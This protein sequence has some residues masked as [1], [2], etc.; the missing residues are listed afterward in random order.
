MENIADNKRIAKNTVLLYIRTIVIMVVSLYTSRVVLAALGV[1]DYGIFNAV[2]GVV[3]MFSVI[4]G[5]L[6][7]SISRYITFELGH[8][9]YERLKDIFSTSINIQL[10]ISII[11][12]VLGETIGLWF[13][14][15]KMNIPVERLNAANWVLHCSLLSFVFNLLS[16]PYNAVIIAHEK[17]SAF[18]YVSIAEVTLKLLIVYALFISPWD[19]LIVYAVLMV[20]VSVVIRLVY[21]FYCGKHFDETKYKRVKNKALV[22]EMTGFAGWGFLTN[23]AYIFNTQGVNILINLFFGVAV[24]AARGI[25]TQ[26]E[27]AL[28]QFVNNFTMA[29][30][31]QITKL[32]AS[33]HIGEMNKLVIRGAK[34]S[35]YLSL[36]ICLPLI[37]EAPYVL[38]LWLVEVPDHTVAFV[39]LS[40]IATMAD[41]I[42][43]TS[44]T[45]CMATGTIK[46]YVLWITS[47]G[48]LVFPLTY[49]AYKFGA[50]VETT[51]IIFFVVYIILDIVRLII[52]KG[53][54]PFPIREFVVEVFLKTILVTA[55]SIVIPLICLYSLPSSFFRLI[56]VILISI[57][58]TSF[59]TYLF[60]LKKEERVSLRMWTKTVYLER[61]KPFIAR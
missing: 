3:A 30:N 36:M 46:K 50:T 57:I 39:R 53:L 31:P 22:R 37:L 48:F 16:I 7:T 55:L 17:M 24:N 19:K 2:G 51:Y 21:G 27:T 25:A 20:L 58:S 13:L 15:Y 18:A 47:I 52:M 8:G 1:D 35:F 54:F 43:G 11:I 44:Y 26:V 28:S 4:S 9:D 40:I 41:R 49:I 10:V 6:S 45:A 29:L 38:K 42:G 14:N 32:Y 33:G 34:F 59:F 5:A 56:I 12:L 60:G 61:I 23:T